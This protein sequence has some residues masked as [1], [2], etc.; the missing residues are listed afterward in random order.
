MKDARYS[1]LWS[2]NEPSLQ[3]TDQLSGLLVHVVQ[4][5]NGNYRV[6]I[7]CLNLKDSPNVCL[8]WYRTVFNSARYGTDENIQL[9]AVEVSRKAPEQINWLE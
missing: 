8:K 5:Q 6:S 3:K 9:N 7:L 4:G 2:D 1:F